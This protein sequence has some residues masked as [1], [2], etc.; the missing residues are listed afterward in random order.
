MLAMH[1]LRNFFCYQLFQ[2]GVLAFGIVLSF[3]THAAEPLSGP[4]VGQTW[5]KVEGPNNSY[6]SNSSTSNT[7]TAIIKQRQLALD[8]PVPVNLAIAMP[9]VL[10]R[11]M[12][13]STTWIPRYSDSQELALG[14]LHHPA[15]GEPAWRVEASR[16]GAFRN[17]PLLKIRTIGSLSK[18]F[19]GLKLRPSDSLFSW[20]GFSYF[21]GKNYRSQLIPEI[22]WKRIGQDGLLIDFHVPKHF[23]LGFKFP[24]FGVTLGAEQDIKPL[25]LQPLDPTLNTP[26]GQNELMKFRIERFMRLQG[27]LNPAETC[28]VNFSVIRSLQPGMES[29]P[30]GLE[31]AAQWVPNP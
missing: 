3:S 11:H 27:V 4:V 23:F 22:A 26:I 28:I 10:L 9:F 8:I 31:I 20:I 24:K 13:R 18:P 15:E 5:W 2:R 1:Y 29:A 7:H 21:S 25:H 12:D 17:S 6:S 30:M 14:L 16:L 19:P